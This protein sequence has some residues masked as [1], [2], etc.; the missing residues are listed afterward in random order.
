MSSRILSVA[1]AV[2]KHRLEPAAAI[3][4][5][6][7]FWP[8]L[9]RLDEAEA[10]LGTRYTCEPVDQL[11]LPRGLTE[12]RRSYLEHARHLAG[13]AARAALARAGIR[14]CD[15]DMVVAVSCTGYLV[16]SL[17]VHLA[18]EL[19]L[20]PPALRLPLPAPSGSPGPAA[21][22]HALLHLP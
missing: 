5:L 18:G 12:L 4:E 17:D 19:G 10:G 3:A 22:P 2:P 8:Q 1:T 16:P 6:R 9:D 7:R 21:L 13:A 20:P 11:L 15:V 14:G